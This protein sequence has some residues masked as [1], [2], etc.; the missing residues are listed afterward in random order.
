MGDINSL[1]LRGISTI[2]LF[3]DSSKKHEKSIETRRF[4]TYRARQ[5]AAGENA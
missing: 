4:R 5:K 2:L 1:D 3:L